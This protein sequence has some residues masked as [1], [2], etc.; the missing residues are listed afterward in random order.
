MIQRLFIHKIYSFDLNIEPVLNSIQLKPQI[1]EK[2]FFEDRLPGERH[3]T[4]HSKINLIKATET[5]SAAFKI[6]KFF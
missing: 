6:H 2:L 5:V 3:W 1:F 4:D